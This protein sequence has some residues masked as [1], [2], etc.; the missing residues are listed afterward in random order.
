M[1]QCKASSCIH[2]ALWTLNGTLRGEQNLPQ[3]K[4]SLDIYFAATHPHGLLFYSQR[5]SA[6]EESSRPHSQSGAGT[7]SS[8]HITINMKKVMSK[9]KP[10]I[11]T[12]VLLSYTNMEMYEH[13]RCWCLSQ[14]PLPFKFRKTSSA[15]LGTQAEVFQ[16]VLLT[17]GARDCTWDLM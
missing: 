14:I 9:N 4:L 11:H 16:P 17:R 1:T 5:P 13:A 2:V 12:L 8:C 3:C 6:Q 10:A 7:G 15:S